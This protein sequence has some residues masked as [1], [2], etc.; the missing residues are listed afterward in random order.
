MKLKDDPEY[1]K[2]FKMLAVGIP[3]PVVKHKM[4]MD[5]YDGGILVS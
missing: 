4:T 2:Y 1:K 5:G 3:L